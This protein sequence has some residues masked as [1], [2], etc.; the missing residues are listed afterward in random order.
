MFLKYNL[1]AVYVVLKKINRQKAKVI[2]S[3]LIDH[4]LD[5]EIKSFIN[6]LKVRKADQKLKPYVKSQINRSTDQKLDQHIKHQIKRSKE[7]STDQRLDQQNIS[8]SNI[9][10]AEMFEEQIQFLIC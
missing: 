5:Q 9:L 7:R 2:S 10:T 4:N 3:K 8:Y 6:R 1:D